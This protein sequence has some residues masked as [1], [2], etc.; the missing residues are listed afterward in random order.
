MSPRFVP[1]PPS[2]SAPLFPIARRLGVFGLPAFGPGPIWGFEFARPGWFFAGLRFAL[3][4][5]LLGF[6]VR[7]SLPSRFGFEVRV[8]AR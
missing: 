8:S 2:V 3:A 7:V 5:F 1:V 4:A 6:C